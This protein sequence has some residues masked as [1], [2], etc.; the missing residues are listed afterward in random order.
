MDQAQVK[1][2]DAGGVHEYDLVVTKGTTGLHLSWYKPG[3]PD[4]MIDS[5]YFR[6]SEA[7]TLGIVMAEMARTEVGL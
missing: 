7:L 2:T 1:L 6:F 5:A 3:D 4:H